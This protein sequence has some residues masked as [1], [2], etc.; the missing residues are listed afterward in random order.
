MTYN[1]WT[2]IKDR[3]RSVAPEIGEEQDEAESFEKLP[4][5]DYLEDIEVGALLNE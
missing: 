4:D 3:T 2:F 1:L 5:I